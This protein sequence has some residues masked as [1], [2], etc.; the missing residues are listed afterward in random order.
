MKK[1]GALLLIAGAMSCIS[2]KGAPDNTEKPANIIFLIGDGMG[3]SA[4][5]STV[6]FGDEV[7]EFGRFSEIGLIITSSASHKITDSGASGTA[8]A[9]GQKTYNGAIGV[10]T[11][12][13]PMEN[14]TEWVSRLGWSTGVV[15]TSSVT[16]ATPASFYAHVPSRGMEQ[17][18]AAQLIDSQI[19]FF[20][21]GGTGYF[22]RR[23]DGRDLLQEAGAKGFRMDTTTLPA[24]GTLSPD[25]KYGFLL[26]GGGMPSVLQGRKDFLPE[27]TTLALQYLSQNESGFFLMV[28][29][30]QIDWEGHGNRGD[31]VVAEMLDFEKAVKVALDFAEKDGSTLVVV[32]ADHETGGFALSATPNEETGSSDYNVITPTFATSG[33]TTTLIPVFAYGPGA[34]S[35]KGMYQNTGIFQT[36]VALLKQE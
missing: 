20:A 14:I 24:P 11:S 28:E 34:R 23:T 26:S 7:S 33:H 35:F 32:S 29:G 8:M 1:F 30:S 9:S 18:I 36:M 10:D 12:G 31:G 15:S 27:A 19:D 25:H 3:L 5:S 4:I 22:A 17:E 13:A 16:H 21:G 6:Y 2:F